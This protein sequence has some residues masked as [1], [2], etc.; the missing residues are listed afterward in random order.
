ASYTNGFGLELEGVLPSAI[1]SVTGQN[2]TEGF[3]KNNANGTEQ[4]QSN[5]V[6]IFFDNAHINVG[7]SKTISIVFKTPIATASLGTAPFNPFLIVNKNRQVEIHL[8]LKPTTNYPKTTTIATGPTVKDSDGNFKSPTGLP[9]AINISGAY[10]APKEKVLITD[11]Y[12]FFATWA[13]SGG[14]NK[15]DWFLDKGGYRNN[16]NLK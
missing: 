6:I 5:A 1:E 3:I 10:R 15:S 8:P 9:W 16:S 2:L 11:A 14:T 7:L 13:T 4:S 12:N